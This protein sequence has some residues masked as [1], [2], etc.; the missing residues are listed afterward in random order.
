MAR[1]ELESSMLKAVD[2]NP[3]SK[4]LKVW[5]M[6]KKLV[7]GD[8]RTGAIY[9]YDN[10][11]EDVYNLLLNAKTDLTYE[12]SHGKCFHRLIISNSDKYPPTKLSS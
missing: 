7:S 1:I 6:D 8:I 9:S 3:K 11:T 5:F 4:E 12:C 10:V 2:Y